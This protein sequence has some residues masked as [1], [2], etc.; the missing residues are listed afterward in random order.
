MSI[1]LSRDQAEITFWQEEIDLMKIHQIYLLNKL[2]FIYDSSVMESKNRL[3]N[4]ATGYFLLDN[5]IEFPITIMDAY[6]FTYMHITEDKI[7]NT[8]MYTLDYAKKHNTTFNIITIVWHANVLKMKGGRKYKDILEYL[9]CQ[10]DVTLVN[11]IELAKIVN[12]NLR[13]VAEATPFSLNA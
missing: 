8:F 11:G 6:L 9:S 10:K 13:K 4:N 7:I 12:A 1:G 5:V 3:G 2:G